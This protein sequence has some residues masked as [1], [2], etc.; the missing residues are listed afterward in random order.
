M[1]TFIFLFC[2][3]L[4]ERENRHQAYITTVEE[5][6]YAVHIPEDYVLVSPQP[7]EPG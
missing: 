5:R 6:K 3:Y 2:E 7:V 4:S 1:T